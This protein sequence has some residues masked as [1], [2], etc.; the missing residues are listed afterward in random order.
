MPV[1]AVA[2]WGRLRFSYDRHSRRI[3][4]GSTNTP[5]SFHIFSFMYTGTYLRRFEV[6]IKT[7]AFVAP[8]CTH[9]RGP[10]RAASRQTW[11]F[12]RDWTLYG[13]RSTPS[14]DN[15]SFMMMAIESLLCVST[16]RCIAFYAMSSRRRQ[17]QPSSPTR[18]FLLRASNS[19]TCIWKFY[20]LQPVFTCIKSV[21]TSVRLGICNFLL[22]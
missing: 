7:R 13:S 8:R 2:D 4:S 22:N 10:R 3:R 6:F 18:V 12:L 9:H 1:H 19:E 17:R 20:S 21:S 16:A 14:S 5:I 15:R 11:T